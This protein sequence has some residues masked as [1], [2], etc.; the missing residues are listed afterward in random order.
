[1]TV[2]VFLSEV[3]ERGPTRSIFM[4]QITI[5]FWL[6]H[7]PLQLPPTTWPWQPLFCFRQCVS[8]RSVNGEIG[9]GKLC[10]HENYRQMY[11]H[12]L[13]WPILSLT[14][15]RNTHCL[16]QKRGCQDR[17]VCGCYGGTIFAITG[18]KKGG[19]I[20]LSKVLPL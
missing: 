20:K 4:L 17:V 11:K 9:Q 1:M 19:L 16:K 5:F 12:N 18:A 6:H 15:L 2:S 14:L 10:L 7:W 13:P 3:S 8:R